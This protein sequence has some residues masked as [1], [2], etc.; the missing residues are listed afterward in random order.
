ML[1]AQLYG[2]DPAG[3]HLTS[4]ALHAVN[5]GLLFLLLAQLTGATWRSLAVA[6]L[7][8]LHPLRVESVAWVSERKDVLSMCFGLLAVLAYGRAVRKF[9]TRNPKLE[10][11]PKP[12]IRCGCAAGVYALALFCFALSLMSK[13][14]FVTLPFLLLLLD[15]WPLGRVSRVRCPVSGAAGAEQGNGA[16]TALSA[17]APPEKT[18]LADKAVRAPCPWSRLVVEKL[19]FL[20]L[21]VVSSVVTFFVQR[22]GGAVASVVGLPLGLRVENALVSYGRYLFKTVWPADLATLY[23]HPGHWPAWH[24]LAAVCLLVGVSL[25]VIAQRRT[26]PFVLVGWF[27][28]VGTLVPVIGLVQVGIQSMADRYTYLPS[29]G[30][31]VALVWLAQEA[32]GRVRLKPAGVA[33]AAVAA[34]CAVA[35]AALTWRQIGFW[36]DTETLFSRA[37]AVTKEN[38]LAYNNLG[39]YLANHGRTAEALTN[40]QASVRLKPD[41]ARTR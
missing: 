3:H 29:V 30:L 36:R 26:W 13:P 18:T 11:S 37:V 22:K 23:P 39:F 17:S 25:L 20:I 35:C 27:W 4:V 7:F 40:Y 32:A 31:L 28:F 19:P 14:M 8:A 6:A 41:H 1:D 21:A 16:R 15:L 12:K 5:A 33:A 10:G 34:C 24:V 9:E 2:Q 38:Y